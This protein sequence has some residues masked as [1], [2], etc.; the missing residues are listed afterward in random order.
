MELSCKTSERLLA[1]NYFGEIFFGIFPSLVTRKYCVL[2]S[3]KQI[4]AKFRYQGPLHQLIRKLS[5]TP[6]NIVS[7][8]I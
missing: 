4:D 2:Y 6:T 7:R 3:K 5:N 8:E 1:V